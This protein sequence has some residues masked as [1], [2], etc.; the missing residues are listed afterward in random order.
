MWKHAASILFCFIFI[1]PPA[2]A[3][4]NGIPLIRAKV[5]A[6]NSQLTAYQIKNKEVEGLSVE[7]GKLKFFY[8]R[9]ELKKIH[10]VMYGEMGYSTEDA[11]FD[12]NQLI[13]IYSVTNHYD[14]PSGIVARREENRYYFRNGKMLLWINP[15]RQH[16]TNS[17]PAFREEE[18]QL[19]RLIDQYIEI[20]HTTFRCVD[21]S[22]NTIAACS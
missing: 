15:A 3:Q 20:S 7:G 18:N 5:N 1:L 4:E 9:K 16:I 8:D 13:F 21:V 14:K 6:I 22:N 10:A 19:L 17:T 2:W 12:R 11:Y